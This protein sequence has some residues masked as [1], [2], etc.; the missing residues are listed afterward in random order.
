[1][2]RMAFRQDGMASAD[3]SSWMN[4]PSQVEIV[5]RAWM[6]QRDIYSPVRFARAEA[7][8]STRAS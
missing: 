3:W 6:P 8:Q 5:V 2:A 7:P 4:R 1:M